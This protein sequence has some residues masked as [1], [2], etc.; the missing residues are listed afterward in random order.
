MGANNTEEAGY[1]VMFEGR[2]Q[3]IYSSWKDAGEEAIECSGARYLKF[4]TYSNAW[5][6]WDR[7]CKKKG[8]D[9]R[10]GN[11]VTLETQT[12]STSLVVEVNG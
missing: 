4:K 9:P 8:H 3:G 10:K 1:Y 7:F 12:S 6:S 11:H 2:N 5:N